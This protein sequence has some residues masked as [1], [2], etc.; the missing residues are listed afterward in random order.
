MDE[1]LSL[2]HQNSISYELVQHPALY[3][4]EEGLSLPHPEAV[5]KNLFFKERKGGRY[6]LVTLP[7]NAKADFKR[8]R[9]FFSSAPLTMAS[10]EELKEILG[11][12]LGS[13]TPFGLLSDPRHRVEW[14]LDSWFRGKLIGVHPNIN[15]ATAYLS[16]DGLFRLLEKQGCRCRWL[17]GKNLG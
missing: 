2:L 12:R 3:H 8:L 5:A 14:G 15:T 17:E 11:L 7:R 13:V 10:P 9:E 16:A 4:M 6:F 1:I